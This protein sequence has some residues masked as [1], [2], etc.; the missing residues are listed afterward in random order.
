MS[1]DFT[2]ADLK[3]ILAQHGQTM[4]P[5]ATMRTVE[6]PKPGSSGALIVLERV[7]KGVTPEYCVHGYASCYNCDKL[8]WLGHETSKVVNDGKAFPVCIE[9]AT[10]VIPPEYRKA[11]GHVRDHR[12]ADGPHE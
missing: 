9:C 12:R 11:T 7:V 1:K 10:V 5:K 3:A 8:C 2:P 6:K 4:H